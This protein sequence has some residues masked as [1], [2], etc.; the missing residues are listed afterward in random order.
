[1]D[2]SRGGEDGRIVTGIKAAETS[3]GVVLGVAVR[4]ERNSVEAHPKHVHAPEGF[5]GFARH[6]RPEA[7]AKRREARALIVRRGRRLHLRL[8]F[9]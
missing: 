6:R 1:M 5:R 4:V 8:A 9:R 3:L 2:E 7:K